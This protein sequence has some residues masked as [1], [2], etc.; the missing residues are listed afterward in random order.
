MTEGEGLAKTW[1]CE[2][3]SLSSAMKKKELRFG[4]FP[5]CLDAVSQCDSFAGGFNSGLRSWIHYA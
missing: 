2:H 1:F 4:F 3:Q 5:L